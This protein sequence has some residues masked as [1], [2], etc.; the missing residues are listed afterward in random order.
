MTLPYNR[1]FLDCERRVHRHLHQHDRRFQVQ[2]QD[3]HRGRKI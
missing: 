3:G 1:L 2:H